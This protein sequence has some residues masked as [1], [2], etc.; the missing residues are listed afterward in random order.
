MSTLRTG[1]EVE[2]DMRVFLALGAVVVRPASHSA[3]Q[4]ASQACIETEYTYTWTF[5]SFTL[6]DGACGVTT[7]ERA[8]IAATKKATVVKK[9]KTFCTRTRAECMAALWEVSKHKRD[10]LRVYAAV[11]AVVVCGATRFGNGAFSA[12]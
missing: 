11:V 7:T 5:C 6:A 4:L 9:P 2:F 10:K 3:L 12:L 8:M 1:I